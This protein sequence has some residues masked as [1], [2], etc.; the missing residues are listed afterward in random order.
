MGL[1][2]RISIC[3][4]GSHPKLRLQKVI[5]CTRNWFLRL[6]SIRIKPNEVCTTCIYAIGKASIPS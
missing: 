2:K 1:V 3:N 6:A 5:M 4:L